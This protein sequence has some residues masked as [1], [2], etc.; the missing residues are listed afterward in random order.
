MHTSMHMLNAA[1]HAQLIGLKNMA[2][3]EYKG[4]HNCRNVNESVENY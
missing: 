1:L 2:D 4:F 3:H